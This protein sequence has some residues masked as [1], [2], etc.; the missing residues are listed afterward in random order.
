MR[1][2]HTHGKPPT[3]AVVDPL[4]GHIEAQIHGPVQE[5]IHTSSCSSTSTTAIRIASTPAARHC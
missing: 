5:T 3:E 2:E 4:D 1:E